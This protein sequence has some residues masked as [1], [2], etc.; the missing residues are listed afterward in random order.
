MPTKSWKNHPKKLHTYGSWEVFFSAA[1]TAQKSPE[2]HFRFINSFIQPSLVGSL[3]PPLTGRCYSGTMENQP[4]MFKFSP[5]LYFS[6]QKLVFLVYKYICTILYIGVEI[7]ESIF[8]FV[9]STKIKRTKSVPVIFVCL[10]RQVGR[11]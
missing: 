9:P 3:C 1:L 5:I 4:K 6:L 11:Q 10:F 8:Y 2:L 7:L